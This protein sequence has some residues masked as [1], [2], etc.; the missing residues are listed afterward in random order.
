MRAVIALL[1]P[2]VALAAV[3]GFAAVPAPAE[4]QGLRYFYCYAVDPDRGTVF[5]SD[6]H[7]VGPVAERAAYGDAFARYLQAKGKA[8]GAIKPFCVMRATEREIAR[9]R[10]ELAERCSECGTI[11]K[12][13][14]VPWLRDKR[15]GAEAL[16]AGKLIKPNLLEGGEATALSGK[17]ADEP[18]AGEGVTILGR[19]D[20]TDV[21][22]SVN[23]KN[24]G[25]LARQKADLKGGRWTTVLDDSRCP[26]WLAVA[27]ASN[28]EERW[29]YVAQGA[30][31]AGE[32]SS[33]ALE[34]AEK[35]ATREGADWTTGV[36]AAL[37]ND[38]RHRAIDVAEAVRQGTVVDAVKGA[39][40]RQ[41]VNGC[42]S[43]DKSRFVTVGVRG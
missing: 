30:D 7:D 33:A 36:L 23:E 26:G 18:A 3:L 40:R 5:A 42:P 6:M 32:A 1:L 35:K 14:D 24:G 25:V 28:G 37:R 39:V 38:F 9:G 29:Y 15:K 10:A 22:Y 12:F 41:V 19:R 31:S 2:L 17:Q 27:Y 20:E 43:G 13:E 8:S 21:T 16:L 4:A 34:A 11:T